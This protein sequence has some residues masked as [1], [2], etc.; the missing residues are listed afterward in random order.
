MDGKSLLH[1]VALI[2]GA[3]SGMGKATAFH[4]SSLGADVALV[5]RRLAL[6]EGFSEELERKFGTSPL[7]LKVDMTQDQD[8][9]GAIASTME[10]YGRI[11]LVVNFAG[12]PSGY[13]S[14]ERRLPIHEQSIAHMKEIAEV[15]HFGSVRILKWALPHMIRQGEGMIILISAITSVYGYSEDV[16]YIPYKRANEGLATSTALRSDRDG[17]GVKLFTLAPGDVYNPS[18]WEAYSEEERRESAKFG[19]IESESVAKVVAWLYEGRLKQ[20][21]EMKVNIDKGEVT[22]EGRYSPLMNGDV[23][24]VDAKTMPKL[25]QEVGEPYDP[26]TPEGY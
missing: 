22:D 7:P 23:I 11:D 3:S 1:K 25:F 13:A 12:N 16:D 9:E 6:V 4:L 21:Y 17:W 8:V 15:D 20:S 24:V 2:T 10:R 26:F 18:T 19:V 14:G 5:A